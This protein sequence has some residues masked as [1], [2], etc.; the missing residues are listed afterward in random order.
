M[1]GF[2]CNQFGK[3]EPG[4]IEEITTFAKEEYGVTFE[5]YNKI[6]VNGEQA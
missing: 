2:P 3:Q 5:I 1:I 6:D 4:S